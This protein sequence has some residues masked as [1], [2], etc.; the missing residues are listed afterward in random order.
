M[1]VTLADYLAEN[2][3]PDCAA[4]LAALAEAAAGL[5]ARLAGPAQVTAT[6]AEAA[7]AAWLPG[8]GIRWLAG[9]AGGGV[10]E[11]DPGG[12][13][14][15]ALDPLEGVPGAAAGFPAATL[16]SLR[17]AGEAAGFL[18]PGTGIVAAGCMLYGARTRMALAIGGTAAGFAMHPSGGRFHRTEPALTIPEASERLAA[19]TAGSRHWETPVRRYLED[20]LAGARYP[21]AAAPELRWTGCLGA[22]LHR[23][24]LQGGLFLAPR[25]APGLP[26]LI[27]QAQPLA[28]LAEAAG[29]RATDGRGRLLE[30]RPS[31]LDSTTPLVFGSAG[32]VARI[33]ACHDLPDSET[34]PLFG[35]RGLFRL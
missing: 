35:Q 17:P 34:S 20:C 15:L 8:A 2:A 18:G 5:A 16:F 19:D 22:E 29:G 26:R 23:I 31:A 21:D 28:A 25:G 1:D 33:T 12:S 13:L 24:L 11:V 7:F 14:A 9:T 27:H 30:L 32:P 4:A 3:G 10:A 6:E